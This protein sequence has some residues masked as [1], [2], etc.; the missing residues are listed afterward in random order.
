[1]NQNM[2]ENANRPFV[3]VLMPFHNKFRDIYRAGIKP[4]CENVG[5]HCERADEQISTES[6]LWRVYSQIARAD[7]IVA[8]MTG[9]NPNVFYEVGYAHALNRQVI[10]LT[11]N[12]EDIPFDL[13]DYPH[14]IYRG[15]IDT[16][17]VELENRIRWCLDNSN[18]PLPYVDVPDITGLWHSYHSLNRNA[19]PVGEVRFKQRGNLVEADIKVSR[20]RNGR[21]TNKQF[22]LNG[23]LTA[24][25][26][27]F[28]YE[29]TKLRGYV[30]GA[31]V[32]KLS[33]DSKIFIGK[34]TYFHQDKSSLEAFNLR[35]VRA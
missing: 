30:I 18:R 24:G 4:A 12:A 33:G 27:A 26:L 20:S 22:K 19:K 34:I 7:V 2:E 32:L 1:M 10:L 15:R 9:R 21:K 23:K 11:K 17:K 3:F 25:Q 16:L 13:K 8:E 6:I 35:L 29:D 5:A 28:I 31:G 14:I